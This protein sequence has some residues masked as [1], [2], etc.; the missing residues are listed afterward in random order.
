[1]DIRSAN[2]RPRFGWPVS[3]AWPWFVLLLEESAANFE[4]T[5]ELFSLQPTKPLIESSPEITEQ[6]LKPSG[7]VRKPI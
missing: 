7:M 2:E 5:E 4:N 3:A 6:A 1:L